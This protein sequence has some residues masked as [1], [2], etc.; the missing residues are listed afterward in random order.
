MELLTLPQT[1]NMQRI[2]S[3]LHAKFKVYIIR[4]EFGLTW[5]QPSFPSL[6]RGQSEEYVPFSNFEIVDVPDKSLQEAVRPEEFHS[7]DTGVQA[8][9]L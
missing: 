8:P 5:N 9:N 3:N 4:V 2:V 1:V 7:C 6:L